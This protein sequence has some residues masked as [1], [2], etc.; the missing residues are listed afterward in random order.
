MGCISG[1]FSKMVN[2]LVLRCSF[3]TLTEHS[4]PFFTTHSPFYYKPHS[5]S[6]TPTFIKCFILCLSAFCNIQSHILTQMN[7]SGQP[8]VRYL[9]QGY[10]DMQAGGC[11]DRATNLQTDRQLSHISRATKIL[12]KMLIYFDFPAQ[13][14][15]YRK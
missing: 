5:P 13:L 7:V 6:Q 12:Q 15:I 10:F 9:T 14:Y 4:K 8:G 1:Y 2:G 11:G 3:F